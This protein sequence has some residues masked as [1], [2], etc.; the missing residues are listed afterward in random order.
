MARADGLA[1]GP[2]DATARG[3]VAQPRGPAVLAPA[4]SFEPPVLDPAEVP[5][6]GEFRLNEGCFRADSRFFVQTQHGKFANSSLGPERTGWTIVGRPNYWGHFS[7]GA[8]GFGRCVSP[9]LTNDLFAIDYPLDIG[10]AVFCPFKRGTVKFVG[11]SETHRNYG[12]MVVIEAAAP[13]GNRYV[14]M[15]AHLNGLAQGIVRGARVTDETIIGFAGK[16]GHPSIPV[17]EPHL[18][19][20][21]Y[22]N[23]SFILVS[24]QGFSGPPFG[25]QGLQVIY[26]HFEGDARGSGPGVYKLDRTTHAPGT[27]TV[28]SSGRFRISN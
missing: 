9:N 15:S 1:V 23:P 20:A 4:A 6:E 19:Q 7:H 27:G 24:G 2:Q 13:N 10:D 11:R 22:R 17:G 26:H 16:T 18:H 14:S 28:P 8:L 25:G 3:L 21:F 5:E 12:I